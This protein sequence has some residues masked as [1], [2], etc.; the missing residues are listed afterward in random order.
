[1][2]DG[3]HGRHGVDPMTVKFK[4][5]GLG[6]FDRGHVQHVVGGQGAVYK[7]RRLEIIDRKIQA[8]VLQS[9]P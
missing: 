7:L 4:P 5:L 2:G 6:N 9:E 1:M 8:V 3:I